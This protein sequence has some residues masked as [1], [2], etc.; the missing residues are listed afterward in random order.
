MET[1]QLEVPKELAEKVSTWTWD[2]RLQKLWEYRQDQEDIELVKQA[3]QEEE[4]SCSLD[5][6]LQGC[7][8]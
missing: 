4:K 3:M 1:I 5:E 7:E 2:L 6:Y 8:K